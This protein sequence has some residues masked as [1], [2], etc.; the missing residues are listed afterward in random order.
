MAWTKNHRQL[1]TRGRIA[2]DDREGY[3]GKPRSGFHLALHSSSNITYLGQPSRSF[4]PTLLAVNKQ[5]R[6]EASSILYKQNIIFQDMR[7]LHIF[8]AKIGPYNRQLLSNLTVMG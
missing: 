8:L 2:V 3:R 6:G 4:V 1:A 7:A 5:I